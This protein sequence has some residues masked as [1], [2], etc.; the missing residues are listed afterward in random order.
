MSP[1]QQTDISQSLVVRATEM[2]WYLNLLRQIG[3]VF[4][5]VDPADFDPT[6]MERVDPSVRRTPGR[7]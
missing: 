5:L 3:K 4:V 6:W 7:S 2:G 1:D